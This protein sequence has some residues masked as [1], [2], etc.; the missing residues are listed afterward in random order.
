MILIYSALLVVGLAGILE[1][2][3]EYLC[4]LV[5][6]SAG[7]R[8]AQAFGIAI[9]AIADLVLLITVIEYTSQKLLWAAYK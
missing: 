4:G 7:K 6:S 5:S 1:L 9:L 2:V 3:S 8:I